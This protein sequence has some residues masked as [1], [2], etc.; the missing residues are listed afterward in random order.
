[1]QRLQVP[2]DHH[3]EQ[4]T[5]HNIEVDN[6]TGQAVE[7]PGFDYGQEFLQEQK[8]E[9]ASKPNFE[10]PEEA[11]EVAAA[12]GQL[13]VG[14]S[15]MP[16]L[17]PNLSVMTDTPSAKDR[18]ESYPTRPTSSAGL[19]SSMADPVLWIILIVIVIAIFFAVVL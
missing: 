3:I 5:W 14:T 11:E 12:S 19:G 15:E 2:S 16:A 4:S 17:N 7:Q 1:M 18:N 10:E 8:A 13:A 9:V 6:K